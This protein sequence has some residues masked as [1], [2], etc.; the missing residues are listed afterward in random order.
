[1]HITLGSR[2]SHLAQKQA[3]IVKDKLEAL[4]HKVTPFSKALHGGFK[5][6]F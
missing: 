3:H 6:R 2:Q 1:M 4:G 5:F